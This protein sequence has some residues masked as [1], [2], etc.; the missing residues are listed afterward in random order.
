MANKTVETLNDVIDM[1]GN[2][3]QGYTEAAQEVTNTAY[4]K[5]FDELAKQSETFKNELRSEVMRFDSKPDDG[6][7]P[8]GAVHRAW[9]DLKSALSDDDEIAVLEECERGEARAKEVYEN[10][11]GTDIDPTAHAVLEHQHQ[12]ITRASESIHNLRKHEQG[13]PIS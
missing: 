5:V 2:R 4:A 8:A 11:L 3:A 10:A 9:L 1:L 6:G 13:E 12:I 7:S